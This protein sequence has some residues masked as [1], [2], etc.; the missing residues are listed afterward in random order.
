MFT[1]RLFHTPTICFSHCPCLVSVRDG[2]LDSRSKDLWCDFQCWSCVEV[3]GKLLI[4]CC[5]SPPVTL[6]WALGGTKMLNCND[7]PYIYVVAENELLRGD[8]IIKSVADDR[9]VTVHAVQRG[10]LD[11]KHGDVH[12]S[13]N[14]LT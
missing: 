12:V 13:I 6:T 2:E 5:L 10:Y 1:K 11:Y 8:A 4:S 14:Y 7:C 9:V 3:L